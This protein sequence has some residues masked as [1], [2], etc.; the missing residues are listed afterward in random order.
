MAVR[1]RGRAEVALKLS[2]FD[3]SQDAPERRY[4]P[5]E[6]FDG[7]RTVQVPA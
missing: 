3:D 4:L 7:R 6:P 5:V 1:L 2:V